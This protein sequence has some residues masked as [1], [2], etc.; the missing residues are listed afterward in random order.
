MPIDERWDRLTDEQWQDFARDFLRQLREGEHE[1][2]PDLGLSC[3]QMSFTARPEHQWKFIL[4]VI[5][6]AQSDDELGHI[7]AG[8]LEHVIGW[9]GEAYITAVEEQ[10]ARD[11]KFARAV[12]GVWRNNMTDEIWERVQAIQRSVEPFRYSND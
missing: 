7:A 6:D 5:R 10:A 1:G 9:H 12:T 3:V 4:L 2:D 8:P 11:P